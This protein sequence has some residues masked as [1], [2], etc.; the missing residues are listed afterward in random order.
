MT[1]ILH[2][3]AQVLCTHGGQASP[4]A[5][6]ARVKVGGQG[7]LTAAHSHSVAGCPFTTPEPAPKPCATVTWTTAALRVKADGQPMLLS[8]SSGLCNGPL[9]VQGP[10]QVVMQQIRVKAT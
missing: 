2:Q 3:G 10:A 6:S 1:Y 4:V 9:G 5:Q 7:V 8:S